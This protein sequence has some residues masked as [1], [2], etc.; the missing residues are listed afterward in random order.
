VDIPLRSTSS[1]FLSGEV[2]IEGVDKT[3][4]FIIDTGASIS[5]ISDKL[6]SLEAISAY[7]QAEKM[8]VYG[9]AGIAENVKTLMLPSVT[10]GSLEKKKISAAVLDLEPVNETSGF[11]QS[12]ILGSNFL[13]HFRVSFDFQRGMIRLEPLDQTAKGDRNY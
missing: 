4:N 9:A 13:H 7:E 11:R 3:W 12:G 5:V 1:G 8:R 2:R 6:A 10:L